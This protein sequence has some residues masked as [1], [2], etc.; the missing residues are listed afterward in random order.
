MATKFGRY[1]LLG[2]ISVG[3]M[4]EVFRGR[5]SGAA[6]FE[7]IV[8]I[9][10][11]LPQLSDDEEF[12]GMF[13]DEAK[14]SANLNHSNIG[15]VFE[16]GRIDDRYFI[17][18][19][20]IHGKDLRAI[21]AHFRSRSEVMPIPMAIRIVLEVCNALEYAHSKRDSNGQLLNIV[22]RDVSPQNVLISYEGAVKLIDFGIA[23]ALSRSNKT[24]TGNL[25]G[26]FDYMSPEQVEGELVDHRSD[27]FALGTLLW[28][29][30][31]GR[32]LF[33]GDNE[34]ATLERVR[35][36]EVELPSAANPSVPKALEQIILRA[37]ARDR[38]QRF[39]RAE[40]LHEELE[41]F[42][43]SHR[44][45]FSSKQLS[46]WMKASFNPDGSPRAPVQPQA[47]MTDA[48]FPGQAPPRPPGGMRRPAR[49][50][51]QG[52]GA[53]EL[54]LP[55]SGPR[56]PGPPRPAAPRPAGPPPS[57]AG[58]ANLRAS[59]LSTPQ[60]PQPGRP[61]AGMPRGPRSPAG[62]AP[63]ATLG[64][65]PIDDDDKPTLAALRDDLPVFG[66]DA[67]DINAATRVS[68]ESA[69]LATSM[70]DG[71]APEV[72]V[73]R[74]SP[75]AMFA[76]EAVLGD[77]SSRELDEHADTILQ[78]DFE[79]PPFPSIS[80]E[81]VVTPKGQPMVDPNAPTIAPGALNVADLRLPPMGGQ[82]PTVMDRPELEEP[83]LPA[84]SDD[85][86]TVVDPRAK[87]APPPEG[88]LPP[89][90]PAMPPRPF[91]PPTAR[92]AS[93]FGDDVETAAVIAPPGVRSSYVSEETKPVGPQGYGPESPSQVTDPF[94]GRVPG[95]PAPPQEPLSYGFE[96][97]GDSGLS[98]LDPAQAAPPPDGFVGLPA[99][100]PAEQQGGLSPASS[101]LFFTSQSAEAIDVMPGIAPGRRWLLIVILAASALL[102]GVAAALV[103]VFVVR[104]KPLPSVAPDKGVA[105]QPLAP[106]GRLT[107]VSSAPFSGEVLVDGKV[108]GK[109]RDA[110]KYS[111]KP[112]PVGD[113]EVEIRDG[114]R[115]FATTVKVQAGKVEQVR[116][117]LPAPEPEPKVEPKPEPKV[118]KPEPKVE[119]KPEPKVEK[120]EPKPEK[121]R[122]ALGVQPKPK[123]RPVVPKPRPKPRG[124]PGYLLVS[125][126]P[127]A[128][129]YV[130]GKPT[131]RNTPTPPSQPLVLGPGAHRITL[132]VGDKR[133]TFPVVISSGETSRLIRTL[134][135]SR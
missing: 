8:A 66:E 88:L 35:K 112:L 67:D 97:G 102:L 93:S 23:K 122:P 45:T 28:E 132:E 32:P 90:G 24:A 11:I 65:A 5:V 26:K 30:V 47:T 81:V 131:G 17:A 77:A 16:F 2:R 83:V 134:P 72:V 70:D 126:K 115:R 62:L 60:P 31:A 79:N 18:M 50:T 52:F 73:P 6:G 71:Q 21:Q 3:G 130:D 86:P 68:D 117:K 13:I 4:A 40:E 7:K 49:A 20:F 94:Q 19:E 101:E 9:K 120:P 1:E 25:K 99:E 78:D 69:E 36:A 34:L 57:P 54:G 92:G 41:R 27:L 96:P 12:I 110:L 100:Q 46:R 87:G 43:Q 127:W 98:D 106:E 91:E 44:M 15:Q 82:A 119:P 29:L 85:G 109:A 95:V 42:A 14:L 33:R 113:H 10:R 123:P 39:Q 59:V 105:S 58:V 74:P 135:V 51:L 22:H 80:P 133:F 37:L 76:P 108:A 61:F 89:V 64:D 129:I 55:P 103:Y 118:E 53:P 75:S 114:K 125:S 48:P 84:F 38:D 104:N 124:K 111:L 63:E 116:V 128:K 121:P 107:L 56:P